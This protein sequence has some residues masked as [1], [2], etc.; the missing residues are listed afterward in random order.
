MAI[1]GQNSWSPLNLS[2]VQQTFYI[3]TV[4][5]VEWFYLMLGAS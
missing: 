5:V 1:V 4:L 3:A 2:P